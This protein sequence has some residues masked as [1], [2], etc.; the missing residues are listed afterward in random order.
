MEDLDHFEREITGLSALRELD[1]AYTGL[2]QMPEWIGDLTQ[3]TTL[4]LSDNPLTELPDSIGR[5]TQLTQ[6]KLANNLLHRLPDSIGDLTRLRTL[7]LSDTTLTDLPDSIGGLT[8]LTRLDLDRTALETAPDWIGNLTQLTELSISATRLETAPD[9]IGNLTQLT[10]LSISGTRLETAPDSIANLTQLTTLG[11]ENNAL[12]HLPDWIGDLTQLTTL[13]LT[14]NPLVSLPDSIGR[15]SRLRRLELMN[16]RLPGLPAACGELH[17]LETLDLDGNDLTDFPSA[18]LGLTSLTHLDLRRNRLVEVPQAIGRLAKLEYLYLQRNR[19]HSLPP[20]LGSLPDLNSLNV[21]D[22]PLPPEIIAAGAEGTTELIEF[23]RLLHTEGEQLREAKLVLVGEGAV[24]KSSLLAALRRE[25]WVEDR[26]TTHGIEIKQVTVADDEGPISLNGWDFGG[27]QIYRPTHQFFFT[28]PAVY[29]VVWKP[30]EGPELGLVDEWISLIRNRAGSAARIHVVATHGGPGQRYA[31][32]DEAALRERYGDMIAGFHHVDSRNSADP[33]IAA[34]KEAVAATA[35]GLPHVTRWYPQTWSS[36]R[37]TLTGSDAPYLEYRAY[38]AIAAEHGLSATSARSLAMNAHALGHWVHY[39]DDPGL[40]ELLI[41]KA[42]WLSVAIGLVL[43]DGATV[44]GGGLLPHRRLAGIWDNPDRDDAHR[45]PHHLQQMF[46]RMM[47]RFELSYRVP[48]LTG[49]EPLSLVAQLLPNNRPELTAAWTDYR[50]GRRELVQICHVHERDGRRLVQPDGLMHRL[51]VLFHRHSLGRD[52]VTKALH[53]STGIVLQDRYGDRALITAAGSELTVRVRGLNPQAFLDHLIQEVREYVEGFWKGLATRVVVPC[54][55]VCRLTPPGHARFDLDK[56]YRRLEKGQTT[57]TCP[58]ACDD[59][60]DA[61]ALLRGLNRSADREGVLLTTVRAAVDGVM[62]TH[63][64]RILAAQDSAKEQVLSRIDQLDDGTRA[65][66]SRVDEQITGL[67]RSLDDDAAD[68]PRLFSLQPLERSLRR[69]GV[70]SQRM[71]LTLWCEHSRLPVSVLEADRP[72][73]G[74]YEIDVPRDWWVKAE[75]F[76]R[77]TSLLLKAALPVGLAAFELALSD[78]QWTA[79]SRQLNLGKEILGSSADLA[80]ELPPADG[81]SALAAQA[82]AEA[83]PIRAEGGLM[84]TLHATLREQDVTF[85]DLRRVR[86]QQGRFLWVHERFVSE[87][88]PPLPVIPPP[89][90][91]AQPGQPSQ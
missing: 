74:V 85:A 62:D 18:I 30:R 8:G 28:D 76:V 75:P 65:A 45:Y 2:E 26:D 61:E 29:L 67:L 25:E 51:I 91:P 23:F 17:N 34:L 88:Q 21:H 43:E 60:I 64:A 44:S 6:L 10:E 69:P 13:G 78:G 54:D 1:L 55:V 79:V 73:A 89:A 71:R 14:N 12:R 72:D 86:D 42:D 80:G 49:G 22:N 36:L 24:G 57:Y 50:P 77:A 16:C 9:W 84:R 33:G 83:A 4:D 70:T 90:E 58:D 46:L 68:G 20:S 87:Y 31:H 63:F 5:L 3:L 53:W 81:D 82:N 59:D 15:L 32:I 37:R 48:E 52:D 66:F 11:L 39:A 47:E 27:Q 41:L 38:E 35:S 40:A 7:D 19:L 56:L